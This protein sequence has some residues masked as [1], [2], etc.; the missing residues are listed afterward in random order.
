MTPYDEF[1]Q[2]YI[3]VGVA[4]INHDNLIGQE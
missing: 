1:N 3:Q 4:P 2:T